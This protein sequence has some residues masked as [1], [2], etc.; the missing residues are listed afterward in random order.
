MLKRGRNGGKAGWGRSQKGKNIKMKS[1]EEGKR[2][3]KVGR[4]GVGNEESG[5][6]ACLTRE[7]Q[8]G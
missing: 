8:K 5:E 6:T 2:R 7:G 3:E 4:C 1:G